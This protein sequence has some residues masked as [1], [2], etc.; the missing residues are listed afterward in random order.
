MGRPPTA[1]AREDANSIDDLVAAAD[2]AREQGKHQEAIALYLRAH[3]AAPA[4][5]Y[6]LF[7]LATL[8]HESGDAARAFELGQRGIALDP[9]QI[10]LLLRLGSIADALGDP[11]TALHFFERVA[12]LDPDVPGID[13]LLADQL[14]H[15]GRVEE[16]LAAFERALTRSPEARDVAHARLF[17]LN[18]TTLLSPRQLA[19]EHFAWGERVAAR[20]Q[21]MPPAPRAAGRGRK[22]RV[23]YLSPDLRDHAVSYFVAP[24]LAQHDPGRF[25]ITVFDTSRASEDE[26]TRQMKRCVSR[27]H[28]VG[29]LDDEALATA[30]RAAGIDVLVELSGHTRDNRLEVL[31][32]KPAPV[33]VTWLGYL[34]TSGLEAMDYRLTDA[35]MDPPGLTESL[36]CEKLVRLPVQACFSPRPDSPPVAVHVDASAPL[37]YGSVNQWSKVSPASRDAWAAILRECPDARLRLIVRGGQNPL[38]SDLVTAEFERRGARPGQIEVFPFMRT[39]DFLDFLGTIDI[40]LDPF[41]YGGGTTTMQCLWMGVPVV[42]LAGDTPV[43]RNAVGPLRAV[44]LNHLVTATPANY[45]RAA[46]ELGR[47]STQRK[48]LRQE[49][50]SRMAG[51]ALTDQ[52]AF[53]RAVER[54]YETMWSSYQLKR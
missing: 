11:L 53:A 13:A 25:E 15:V 30:I 12:R 44:G 16:G 35:H 39:P 17:C 48:R 9:D 29:A 52:V 10:G 19:N 23:G 47:D 1:I 20:V 8:V 5:V 42:T 6:P 3:E 45:A 24:L 2:A 40:A 33:Q 7:W 22:L 27:W 41:P 38:L 31:A 49:L 4:R 32:R 26:M 46:I 54:A 37:T 36:H 51:S 43:S 50:R 18:F 14:C 34:G 21:R 28:R